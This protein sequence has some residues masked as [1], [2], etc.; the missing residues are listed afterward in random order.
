M[1]RA[2]DAW[3]KGMKPSNLMFVVRGISWQNIAKPIGPNMPFGK[4]LAAT[5]DAFACR[6]R[7]DLCH[8]TDADDSATQKRFVRLIPK[9][10]PSLTR[11]SSGLSKGDLP[12][13]CLQVMDD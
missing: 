9:F 5:E 13:M 3:F 10:A 6:I 7:H 12:V 2:S 1:V 8:D 4:S 11:W